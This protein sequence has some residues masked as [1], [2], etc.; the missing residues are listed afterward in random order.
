MELENWWIGTDR[1]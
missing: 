1:W